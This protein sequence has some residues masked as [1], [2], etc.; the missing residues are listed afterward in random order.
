MGWRIA[1]RCWELESLRQHS[2]RLAISSDPFMSVLNHGSGGDVVG[3]G[4]RQTSRSRLGRLGRLTGRVGRTMVQS[5]VLG[6]F[7]GKETREQ[8]YRDAFVDSARRVASDL[9]T[10]KGAAMKLGQGLALA[11]DSLE[12]PEAVRAQLSPLH[13]SA[14]PVPFDQIQ[15]TIESELGGR[16]RPIALP[17]CIQ[18]SL[19]KN[20]CGSKNDDLSLVFICLCN[21][22]MCVGMRET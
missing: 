16:L 1:P 20:L 2:A 13:D 6:A 19:W 11:A 21:Q 12:L 5:R 10:L 17:H 3:S 9:G 18:A 22:P 8:L 15:S 14:E 7:R 4:D